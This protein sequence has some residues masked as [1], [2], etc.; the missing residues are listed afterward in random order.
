MQR[1]EEF[2]YFASSQGSMPQ[3]DCPETTQR[4]FPSGRDDITIAYRRQRAPGGHLSIFTAN[5]G[6]E[7]VIKV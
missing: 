3:S 2:E 6:G 7:F 5:V 4:R 1:R